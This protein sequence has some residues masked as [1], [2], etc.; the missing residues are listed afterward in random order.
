[1][2]LESKQVLRLLVCKAESLFR[3]QPMALQLSA[4]LS[5]MLLREISIGCS[6]SLRN[7]HRVLGNFC[8]LHKFSAKNLQSC[9]G[10]FRLG[11]PLSHVKQRQLVDTYSD[12]ILGVI[13]QRLLVA[14]GSARRPKARTALSPGFDTRSRA[15]RWSQQR[16]TRSSSLRRGLLW[17]EPSKWSAWTGIASC[18]GSGSL[19]GFSCRRIAVVRTQRSPSCILPMYPILWYSRCASRTLGFGPL[20]TRF[21]RRFGPSWCWSQKSLLLSE[22]KR[23]HTLK[24][25]ITAVTPTSCSLSFGMYSFSSMVSK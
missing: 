23:N 24:A 15:T 2:L 13:G 14:D 22:W 21:R 4:A 12:D 19:L 6:P 17:P 5:N 3:R 10:C 11:L 7:M 16:P 9:S 8:T 20:N 1:M 18:L 25:I